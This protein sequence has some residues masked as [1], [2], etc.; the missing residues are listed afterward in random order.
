MEAMPSAKTTTT[1]KNKLIATALSLMGLMTAMSAMIACDSDSKGGSNK[2]EEKKDTT[3]VTPSTPGTTTVKAPDF[4]IGSDVSWLSE[5]ESDG[6][7]FKNADGQV[8]DLFATLKDL[9]QNSIRLRVWVNPEDS[10]KWSGMDDM[11]DLAKRADAAGLSLMIDFHYS[12]FFADPSR[13][14]IP[15]DWTDHSVTALAQKVSDHTEEV[16]EALKG[17]NITPVWV[18]IGNETRNGMLWPVGQLWK[19]DG[20]TSEPGG[21]ANFVKLFNA[22]AAAAR[23]VF[24]EIKVI[25]HLNNVSDTDNDLWWFETFVQNGADFDIVGFS[26]YPMSDDDSKT[27]SELNISAINTLKRLHSSVDKPVVIVETG[28]K[29]SDFTAGAECITNEMTRFK[30]LDWC[31]GVF[32][33]E[34]EVYG[35]W[36]PAIYDSLGWGSYDKAAF[37]SDG[38]PS[39]ALKAMK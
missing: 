29:S 14:T 13:Q 7:T 21:W 35:G 17:E 12:D 36:K 18:Q 20:D 26:H 4:A 38:T 22:G 30:G 11:V 1:M 31:E 25:A 33:W 15:A 27:W 16:L 3:T 5:M 19:N 8:Q 6:V 39:E 34:P 2:E 9:G 37:N 10:H 28:I 32:Y 24:P 23:A